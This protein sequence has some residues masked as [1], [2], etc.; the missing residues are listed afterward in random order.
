MSWLREVVQLLT[1]Y[2]SRDFIM[3]KT[4]RNDPCPCGSGNKYM[5]CCMDSN[6]KQ[7]NEFVEELEHKLAMNPDLSLDELNLIAERLAN[8]RNSLAMD[9]FCGLSPNQI[10]NWLYAPSQISTERPLAHRQI[11]QTALLC[12]ANNANARHQMTTLVRPFNRPRA[13]TLT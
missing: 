12:C 10:Q 8:N 11:F 6:A 3:M 13:N 1:I 9:D 2:V 5:R 4:G 7:R